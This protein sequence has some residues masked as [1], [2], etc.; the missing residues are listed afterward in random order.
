M[1]EVFAWIVSFASV[2]LFL[3]LGVFALCKYWAQ[4]FID[5]MFDDNFPGGMA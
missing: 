2:I 5:D 4:K 3:M 1:R